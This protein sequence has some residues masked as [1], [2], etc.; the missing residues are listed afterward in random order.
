MRYLTM[1]ALLLLVAVPAAAQTQRTETCVDGIADV[2]RFR[3]AAFTQN[4]IRLMA[5]RNNPGLFFIVFDA[6][7]DVQGVSFSNSR[8]VHWWA[9]MLSGNHDVWVGCLR[10]ASYTIQWVRNDWGRRLH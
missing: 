10:N 1:G 2:Y 7:A 4:E 8:S 3:P 6:D 5:G 9:G